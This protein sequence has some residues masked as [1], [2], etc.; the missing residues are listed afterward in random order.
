MS[1]EAHVWPMTA[2][3]LLGLPDDHVER[4]LIRGELRERPRTLKNRRHSRAMARIGYLLEG[5]LE[6]QP[7]PRG[8]VFGGEAGFRLRRDPDTTVGMDVAYV[9]AERLAANPDRAAWIEGPPLLAVEI[10]S[11]SDTQET[12]D[13]K[14]EVYLESG[15]ALIW[16]VD[17]RFRTVRVY[18]P[19]A[20]PSLYNADHEITAEPHLPGFRAAVSAFF[21]G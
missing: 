10:L 17:P 20:E 16:I 1:T 13:E 6:T 8:E 11:P 3:D 19:D 14:I 15:V 5:W 18:R 4:E 12:I 9:S 2:E 21:G 7:E